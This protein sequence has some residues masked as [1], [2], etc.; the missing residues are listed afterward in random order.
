MH[1][2]SPARAHA[3]SLYFPEYASEGY[4]D[5]WEEHGGGGEGGGGGGTST[6]YS[7]IGSCVLGICCC[8][9]SPPRGFRFCGPVACRSPHG[10]WRFPRDAGRIH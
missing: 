1:S 7:V 10:V 2:E 9:F 6:K 8:C 3:C 4:G 5:P